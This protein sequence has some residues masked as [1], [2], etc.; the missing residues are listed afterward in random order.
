LITCPPAER[1]LDR[2]EKGLYNY[3]QEEKIALDS[4]QG[5]KL[6]NIRLDATRSKI[7][8]FGEK[9]LREIRRQK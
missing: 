1:A 4:K 2:I 9:T 8:L 7:V 5:R 3:I 6:N